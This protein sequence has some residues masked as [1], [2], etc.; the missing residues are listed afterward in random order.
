MSALL[1]AAMLTRAPMVELVE[2][3]ERS[4]VKDTATPACTPVLE[5]YRRFLSVAAPG[6]KP[7]GVR[8]E[9]LQQPLVPGRARLVR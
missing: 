5:L 4:F 6:V 3:C 9:V 7:D 2:V 8:V 1:V